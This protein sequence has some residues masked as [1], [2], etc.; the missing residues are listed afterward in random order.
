MKRLRQV[1]IACVVGLM[2]STSWV[3]LAD[4]AWGQAATPAPTAAQDGPM[5][6]NE[7]AERLNIVPVFTIVGKD[8]APVLANIPR[9]GKQVQV[10]SFWLDQNQANAV[11][12]QIKKTSPDIASQAQVVPMSLG[13]A[14]QMAEGEKPAGLDIVFQVLPGEGEAKTALELAKKSGESI[15]EFPGVP[16]FYGISETGGLLTVEREGVEIIPF[17][18]SATDLQNA[19]QRMSGE[20]ADVVKQARIEV[21]SLAQVVDQ[22]LDGNAKSEV[23]KIAFVPARSA[24]EYIQ[25]LPPGQQTGLDPISREAAG[26]RNSA[27]VQVPGAQP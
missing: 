1:G 22:M 13:Y 12:E 15:T 23:R 14:Y 26:I 3:A 10:A 25:K 21:T 19:L 6:R 9:D 20:N 11:I 27:P 2:A 24:L 4:T 17:F 5:S 16:L 7:V 8:G 18:F